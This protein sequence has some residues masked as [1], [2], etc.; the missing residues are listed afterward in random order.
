MIPTTKT[1]MPCLQFP[2]LSSLYFSI[3]LLLPYPTRLLQKTKH[4]FQVD[5]LENSIESFQMEHN[6]IQKIGAAAAS[7]IIRL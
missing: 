4:D 7:F 3:L 6:L 1:N 2:C 5:D